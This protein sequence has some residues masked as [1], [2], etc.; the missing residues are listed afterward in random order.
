MRS[1][2]SASVPLQ[3]SH[4]QAGARA[5]A[6]RSAASGLRDAGRGKQR[7]ASPVSR[8][9]VVPTG[10]AAR[11]CASNPPSPQTRSEPAAL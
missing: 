6:A 11:S 5:S 1:I 10:S 7:I 8:S 3:S 9:T 2:A 4:L